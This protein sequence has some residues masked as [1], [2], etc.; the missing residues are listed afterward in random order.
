MICFSGLPDEVIEFVLCAF[1][2][3][4]WGFHPKAERADMLLTCKRFHRLGRRFLYRNITLST[5]KGFHCFFLVDTQD[6]E[7]ENPHCAT[8]FEERNERV[9]RWSS[10]ANRTSVERRRLDWK[11][12]SSSLA[13]KDWSSR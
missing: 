4:T 10:E 8:L 3:Q 11:V 5:I 1:F 12:V 6:W 13:I 7:A 2:E 9:E